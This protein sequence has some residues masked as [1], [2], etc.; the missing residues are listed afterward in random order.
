MI[1]SDDQ[2]D[3]KRFYETTK[4]LLLPTTTHPH[5]SPVE[6]YLYAYS[7]ISTRAF[8]IDIYHTLA[9][10]PFADILNHSSTAHTSLASDDFVCHLCGKLGQCVHDS[11]V[12]GIPERLAHV[13]P[14]SRQTMGEEIDTV[15]MRS[16]RMVQRGE[17]VMNSY[18][19]GIGDGRLLVEWGFLEGEYAGQGIEWTLDELL[20]HTSEAEGSTVKEIYKSLIERGAIALEIYPDSDLEADQEMEDESEKLIGPPIKSLT[21]SKDQ[22]DPILNLNHHGQLSLNIWIALFL[23]S[24]QSSPVEEFESRIVSSINTVELA[25]IATQPSMDLT[26]L[27]TCRR[28]V[29]LLR[30]RMEGMYKYSIPMEEL[31][32]LRDVCPLF[33]IFG[34]G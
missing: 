8:L 4:H 9:L 15:E 3:L 31:L 10:V 22:D 13:D 19:K 34:S 33:H 28:V 23:H 26:T 25:N 27:K 29:S 18:G 17:E 24:H 12:E 1:G 16:E 2:E 32:D 5:P 21:K 11:I 14:H 7:L 30:E 6:A 20:E